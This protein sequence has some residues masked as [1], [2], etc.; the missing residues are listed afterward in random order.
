M[1]QNIH[2]FWKGIITPD[3]PNAILPYR[4]NL[5]EDGYY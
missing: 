5:K 1:I 4:N 3:K 2:N